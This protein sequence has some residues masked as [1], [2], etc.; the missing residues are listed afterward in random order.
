MS[1]ERLKWP[2]LHRQKQIYTYVDRARSGDHICYTVTFPICGR[3]IPQWKLTR[4]LPQIFAEIAGA[5]R[6]R[7]A[8]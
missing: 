8:K 7:M 2:G 6:Q 1:V 5:W 3:T 4:D